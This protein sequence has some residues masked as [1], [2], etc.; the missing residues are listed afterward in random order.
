MHYIK[1]R[2]FLIISFRRKGIKVHAA[3][4]AAIIQGFAVDLDFV[5]PG[6]GIYGLAP[7]K[8]ALRTC[9]DTVNCI[10]Y[11]SVKAYKIRSFK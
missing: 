11:H 6:I 3:N 4:S 1:L 8:Y 10:L 2:I 9:Y 5:R 7:G